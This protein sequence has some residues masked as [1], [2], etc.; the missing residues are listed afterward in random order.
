MAIK[1]AQ[2][3]APP[4][5]PHGGRSALVAYARCHARVRLRP[6]YPAEGQGQIEVKV[7]AVSLKYMYP[8][9]KLAYF[10]PLGDIFCYDLGQVTLNK[11]K[12]K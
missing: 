5:S 6:L 10:W 7:M 1:I 11:G 4:F 8:I 9:C 2:S 12:I 3:I